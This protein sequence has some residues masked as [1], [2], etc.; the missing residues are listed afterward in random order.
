MPKCKRL[1]VRYLRFFNPFFEVA[2]YYK[3]EHSEFWIVRLPQFFKVTEISDP[4]LETEYLLILL[5]FEGEKSLKKL[6]VPLKFTVEG[7]KL[8]HFNPFSQV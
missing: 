8:F 2:F 6:V 3:N 4:L 7:L 1:V 5:Y